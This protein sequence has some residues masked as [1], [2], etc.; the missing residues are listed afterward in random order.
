MAPAVSS[1]KVKG[2]RVSR[3]F[4]TTY[5]STPT[6]LGSESWNLDL[7][8]KT[9]GPYPEGHTK[10]WR[11][12]IKGLDNGPDITTWLKK[13]MFKLHATYADHTR[14]VEA[15]GPFEVSE[16]GYGEFVVELR[17]HFEPLASERPQYRTHSLRLEPF[18]DE[19]Q[20][21]RQRAAGRVVSEQ[22]ELIEFNEPPE[23]FYQKMISEEQ[24]AHLQVQKK[25]GKA[26][27]GKGKAVE[28][29]PE[30]EG[31]VPGA[32]LPARGDG[33]WTQQTEEQVLALLRAAGTDL[34]GFVKQEQEL[35]EERAKKLRELA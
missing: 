24:F 34:E 10:G 14:T 11:V 19:A 32:G 18:G 17:M 29:R 4:T 33:A 25:P 8:D 16:T 15:P 21:E 2:T 6:V 9:K 30:Y 27:K 3:Y 12:Y 28:K 26:G 1:K 23:A 31:E 20:Q 5:A 35:A 13:V 7:E 22:L